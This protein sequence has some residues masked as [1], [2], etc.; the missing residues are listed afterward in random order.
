MDLAML[1]LPRPSPGP[2]PD[3]P[4]L[5]PADDTERVRRVT[6]RA[7][8]RAPRPD[9]RRIAFPGFASLHARSREEEAAVKAGLP[10]RFWPLVH[11]TNWRMTFPSLPGQQER[12]AR[13]TMAEI[14]TRPMQ[15]FLTA[16]PRI[17]VN[18]SVLAFDYRKTGSETVDVVVYDPNDPAA[19][20]VIRFDGVVQGPRPARRQTSCS[21]R[22]TSGSRSH[23][24]TSVQAPMPRR[25]PDTSPV[26]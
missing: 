1:G 2:D 16:F 22:A 17:E 8:W 10:E 14:R 3:R 13:E 11:W 20:G 6:R 15:P 19:P 12:V 18:H 21:R 26:E 7:A 9:A 4:R 25:R 5:G 23:E 24:S